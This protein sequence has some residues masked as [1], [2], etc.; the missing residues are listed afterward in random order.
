MPQL[1]LYGE[2]V[3]L[4]LVPRLGDM[5]E[6][7]LEIRDKIGRSLDIGPDKIIW[8]EEA[9]ECPICHDKHYSIEVEEK[10]GD[11]PICGWEE[12]RD[13]NEWGER[14]HQEYLVEEYYTVYGND[15][16]FMCYGCY[17]N[18]SYHPD[19]TI[20]VHL[21]GGTIFKAS[22]MGNILQHFCD[23][24][25]YYED[26][27]NE[28]QAFIESIVTGTGYHKIDA[29]RGQNIPPSDIGDWV[30]VLSG[31]HS[32]MESSEISEFLNSLGKDVELVYPI[33]TVFTY[34]SNVCSLGIDL[35]VHEA[36]EEHIR[37]LIGGKSAFGTCQT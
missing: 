32:S 28:I 33:V 16:P 4:C 8:V 29:W 2:K 27:P 30:D 20:A 18:L 22:Y 15:E 19:G 26:L 35:Y 13:F 37:G 3:D 14:V 12:C 11:C 5:T 6:D 34:G 1:T 21:P 25:P 24:E 7:I 17:E 9:W 10:I 36:N 31:W 23:T